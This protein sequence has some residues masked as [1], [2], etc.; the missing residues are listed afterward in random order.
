MKGIYSLKEVVS[1]KGKV[2]TGHA[3]VTIKAS[4]TKEMVYQKR[5]Y[6]TEGGTWFPHILVN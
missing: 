3:L 5:Y 4:L 6:C 1:D 2:N